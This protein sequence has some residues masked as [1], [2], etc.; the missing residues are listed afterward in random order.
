[1]SPPREQL[2]IEE[3]VQL[4]AELAAPYRKLRQFIYITCLASGGIGAFVFFFR[5]LAGRAL[6]QTLP[7]LA[8]QLGISA[9]AIALFRWERQRQRKLEDR[10]REKFEVGDRARGS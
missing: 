4:T 7:S 3:R 2:S 8:L 10:L 6:D 1:M 9:G 5:A